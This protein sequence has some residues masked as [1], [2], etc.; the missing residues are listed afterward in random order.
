MFVYTYN[1]WFIIFLTF[2]I[3][4]ENTT[5]LLVSLDPRTI[6]VMNII[7]TLLMGLSLF[8]VTRGYLGQIKG[9]HKWGIAT[10]IQSLGWLVAG[11]L[12]GLIPDI[13]SIVAGNSFVLISLG[14]YYVIISSINNKPSK[15]LWVCTVIGINALALAYYTSVKPDLAMRITFVSASSAI[16]MLGSSFVLFISKSYR[17]YSHI[18]TGILF[19][20]CGG[21][22]AS[23]SIYTFVVPD[24]PIQNPFDPHPLQD[25]SYLTFFITSVMLTFAFILMCNDRYIHERSKAEQ[26]LIK[27]KKLAEELAGAKDQ[28]LSNMSHEIRTPLNGIIGFTKVLLQ[29][30]QD[31]LTATQRQ[32]IGLIKSS[33]DILLVLINDILDLAKINEGKMTLVEE[34]FSPRDLMQDILAS[35][36]LR[37]EE[38]NL[39]VISRFDKNIP[40]VLIGDS[41]RISQILINLINN[42]KKFTPDGG[43]ITLAVSMEKDTDTTTTLHFSVT[44]TG[45]GIDKKKLDA[46]FEPFVQDGDSQKYEGTGLGLSIVKRLVNLMNGT[47]A[48]ESEIN[49]GTKVTLVLSFKKK[50]VLNPVAKPEELWP[51]SS[52]LTHIGELRILLAEDNTINQLLAQ[53][54]LNQFGF[55]VDTAENGKIAIDYVSKNTYDIVLMDLKMPEMDGYETSRYI[56]TKFTSPKSDVPIIAITADVTKADIESYQAS[57]MNDYIIKPFNQ[58]ELLNKIVSFTSAAKKQKTVNT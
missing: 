23:R 33:S 25:I 44:D 47:I 53:T 1:V 22:L 18:L 5:L 38:K 17:P 36:Q 42:S 55:H 29:E 28:F 4:L 11:G 2:T 19:A 32:Q 21:I 34:E 48:I 41:V 56:R 40:Q 49:Q 50:A 20:V 31:K 45:I 26:E 39:K 9:I 7:G 37:M 3:P 8:V 6:M 52:N 35:F 27:S 54:I 14:M 15:P 30:K 57:G 51:E 43:S 46:V 10:L 24:Y 16:L 12:R 58:A 13:I